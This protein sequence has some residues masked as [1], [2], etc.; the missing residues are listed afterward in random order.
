[1]REQLA[2]SRYGE[3]KEDVRHFGSMINAADAPIL[4]AAV[5]SSAGRGL[6]TG[7]GRIRRMNPRFKPPGDPG[8][9]IIDV[10]PSPSDRGRGLMQQSPPARATNRWRP[11]SSHE[12]AV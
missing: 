12:S 4:A 6:P 5:R 9:A 1:V 3:G 11:V 2:R 7:G 8:A 10:L